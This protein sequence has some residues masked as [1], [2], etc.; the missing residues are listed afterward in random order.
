MAGILP[1]AYHNNNVYFLLGRETVD[2]DHRAMGQWSDFGGSIEKGETLKQTAIREGFEE[3]GGLF[4]NM[5]DI[6][7]LID[8]SLIKKFR[9]NK[10]TTFVIQ[11]PYV[12]DLPKVHRE[13]YLD[14]LKNKKHLVTTHNGLYEKD[15]IKWVKLENL[16]KV[17][18]IRPWYKY[19]LK[20]VYKDFINKNN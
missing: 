8:N 15:M 9:V 5:K 1:V 4:G 2:V 18:N 16:N 7:Y 11:V 13:T 17:K 14:V 12:K 20:T 19:V 10:Y 3:T 6:E